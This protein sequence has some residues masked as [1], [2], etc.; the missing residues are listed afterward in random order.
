MEKPDGLPL[1]SGNTPRV[2]WAPSQLKAGGEAA[3]SG[4]AGSSA[5]PSEDHSESLFLLHS[6]GFL[7]ETAFPK[8]SERGWKGRTGKDNPF[9]LWPL[10]RHKFCS[11]NPTEIRNQKPRMKRHWTMSVKP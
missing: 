3:V 6:R 11:F 9:N 1:P 2:S 8:R 4:G 7:P 5:R 10:P